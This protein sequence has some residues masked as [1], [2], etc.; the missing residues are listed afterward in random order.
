MKESDYKEIAF[1]GKI[2]AGVTHEMKNVLAIIKE[3]SGL[4]ED[5]MFMLQEAPLPHEE[6][7]KKALSVIKEQ[8]QRGVELTSRLNKFAHSTD[9]T[10]SKID[11]YETVEVLVDLSQR[12]ARLKNVVLKLHPP[13]QAIAV[14]TNPVH[15]QMGLLACFEC[16]LD[17][18]S[19]GG[20]IDIHLSKTEDKIGVQLSCDGNFADKTEFFQNIS[21]SEKWSRLEN[22]AGLF[23]GTVK[24]N[25]EAC[26]LLL[27]F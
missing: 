4:M 19:E 2:T 10:T 23:G 20:R 12:F 24:Q 8:I 11:L 26:G 22:I 18:M 1:F 17:L 27:L 7:I 16:C 25:Q 3:S 14:E 13:D 9:E 6:K 21:S 15:L 5:L